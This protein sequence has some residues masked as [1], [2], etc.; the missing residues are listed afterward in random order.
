MK[1]MID[2]TED[3]AHDFEWFDGFAI[4]RFYADWCQ[5]CVQHTHTFTCF[6][7]QMSQDYPELKFGQVNIDHSPIVTLRHKVFGLPA[8]LV[9]YQG[10]I[11]HRIAGLKSA[12]ELR[13]IVYKILT[14]YLSQ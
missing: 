1:N 4:I 9:F 3:N 2:Y 7:T 11:I 8:I 6:V 13:V 5:P 10:Q 12:H 14:N